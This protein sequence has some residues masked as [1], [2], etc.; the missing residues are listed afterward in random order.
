MKGEYLAMLQNVL[1]AFIFTILAFILPCLIANICK[2]RKTQG[3][4]FL[5]IISSFMEVIIVFADIM[6]IIAIISGKSLF[7]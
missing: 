6:I 2:N 4:W 1:I 7:S 3:P 5:I